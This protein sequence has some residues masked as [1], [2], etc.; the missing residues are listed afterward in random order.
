[1][2][3]KLITYISAFL[4]CFLFAG[5]RTIAQETTVR[6]KLHLNGIWKLRLDASGIGVKNN[7][8]DSSFSENVKLPGSLEENQKGTIVSEATTAHLNQTR[9]YIG[10]AWYQQ[11]VDIP[12]SWKDKQVELFLERTKA[13]RVWVDRQFV[14]KSTL[15]SAPQ[16]YNLTGKLA[17][18]KHR[19]TILVDNSPN[20]VSV[21]GSHAL[22]EHTQTNWNGIIG[23]MYLE[24]TGKL[25]IDRVRLAPDVKTRTV[26]MALS[27]LNA[28]QYSGN[29]VVELQAASGNLPV[30]HTAE[31]LRFKVKLAGKDTTLNLAYPLGEKALLWSEY[32]PALYKLA[33]CIREKKQLCDST[34]VVFGLREFK[35]E[36]T[37]FRINDV[38][39]FLRGKNESCVFPLTGYPPTDTAAWRKLFRIAK[40]YGINH[41]RF[42]SWTPPEAAFEAADREGIYI[43]AELPNWANFTV[44]DTFHTQFQYQEGK[45]ILDAYGNHPSFV[46]FTLGNELVGDEALINKMVSDFRTYDDTRRLYAHG[47]NAFYNEPHPGKTDDFWVTMRTGKETPDGKYDV[48]GSFATTEDTGNGIINSQKPSVRRDFSTAIKA[49]K[50]PVIGHEIGQY[51]VYPDYTEIPKYSGVLRPLNF[52]IFQQRLSEAG[53][54]DEAADFFR[55]SGKLAALL[56][57]EEIEMALRTPGFAGFQLL[58]LEDFPGQGT[59]LVG[60]L[61]AFMENK[62]LI[63]PGEFRRFNN[64][65]VIQLLM[66]KYTW[67]TDETFTADAQLVNYSAENILGK[68]LAWTIIDKNKTLASGKLPV[69]AEKGKINPLGKISFPLQGISKAEKLTITLAL[70]GTELR[71]EYPVWVYPAKADITVPQ[72]VTVA[73]RLDENA[74][75]TLDSGG[76]VLLF[77]D[78]QEIRDKSVK[79]QFIS[80]FWNWKVFKGAAEN[81]KRPVSAG[82][83]G[84]FTHPEHPVFNSF[85][86]DFY[87][88]WQWWTIV[89]N[90]RPLILDGTDRA[91]RPIVQVIDNIDRNH[92]LGIIFEFKTGRGKL[93]ICTANL[94]Q[95]M[96]DPAARQLYHSM[97][98]YASSDKFNPQKNISLQQLKEL[99]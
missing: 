62:G 97:L 56:Y 35:P 55:A 79:G 40:T 72:N 28:G 10:A 46:L 54:G 96:N 98:H 73:T 93:L 57:R 85:P 3:K 67:T 31:P 13:T 58:D 87:S 61:N 83:L 2:P 94:L 81:M 33:I 39:T 64:D 45:A 90:S 60:L 80:E 11:E 32:T 92:K 14:A 22:S 1:M 53:M 9:Q 20:L 48:R 29:I 26:N 23:D 50:L 12:G 59:A 15:L 77:P 25:K 74:I 4:L 68:E 69:Q 71:S 78:H 82:T 51:Q 8:Q 76:R 88:N 38:I 41:Y 99:L 6:E 34:S 47:T 18:G 89:K 66:D 42:H 95:L 91:Y 43:Q 86:T 19:L 49:L 63:T 21:G 16:V 5:L 27:L 65:V 44:K 70:T 17:P 75:A 30:T 24:A 52:K 7:W 37:Q 84:I 36:G